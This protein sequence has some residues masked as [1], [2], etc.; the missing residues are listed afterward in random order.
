L[1]YCAGAGGDDLGGAE[2]TDEKQDQANAEE[3][4][5]TE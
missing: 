1:K 4:T 5:N 2:I 3:M